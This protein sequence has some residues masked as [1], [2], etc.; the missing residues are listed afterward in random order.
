MPEGP[1]PKKKS[2]LDVASEA[3]DEDIKDAEGLKIRSKEDVDSGHGRVIVS[4][5][6]GEGKI[7]RGSEDGAG[8]TKREVPRGEGDGSQRISIFWRAN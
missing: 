1:Q 8:I 7:V 6:L 2:F 4:S 5:E 3:A